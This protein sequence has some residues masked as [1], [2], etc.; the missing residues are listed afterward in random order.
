MILCGFEG[1]LGMAWSEEEAP[2]VLLAFL[3]SM[4]LTW[5]GA[6][7]FD[8]EGSLRRPWDSGV[9]LNLVAWMIRLLS[10]WYSCQIIFGLAKR[11]SEQSR[12]A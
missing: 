8:N 11:L 9:G 5:M 3:L 7:Q 2:F 10:V 12:Q 6:V 1:V 4:W